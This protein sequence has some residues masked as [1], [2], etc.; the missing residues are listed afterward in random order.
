MWLLEESR[1]RAKSEE[2]IV[3]RMKN[4]CISSKRIYIWIKKIQLD[5]REMSLLQIRCQVKIGILESLDIFDSLGGLSCDC[6]RLKWV[7]GNE[8]FWLD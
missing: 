8:T 5:N 3:W 4:V 1:N 7:S 2:D 6:Y